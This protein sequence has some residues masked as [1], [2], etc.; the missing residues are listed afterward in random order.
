MDRQYIDDH[1]IVERYLQGRLAAD[2]RERFEQYYLEHP[3]MVDELERTEALI[4][5]L[6]SELGSQTAAA[7]LNLSG[8]CHRKAA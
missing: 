6:R 8:I 3:E 2:E 1:Q 5:G 7:I 4:A